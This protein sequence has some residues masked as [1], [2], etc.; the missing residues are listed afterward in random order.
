MLEIEMKTEEVNKLLKYGKRVQ[1]E[2][3]KIG[4]I[5]FDLSNF[6]EKC[7]IKEGYFTRLNLLTFHFT[8]SEKMSFEIKTDIEIKITKLA[9][10]RNGY[11][12]NVLRPF[13]K[14][15]KVKSGNRGR[16]RGI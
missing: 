7:E 13:G 1:C 9:D 15:R 11:S 10:F 5:Y 4:Y 8:H 16:Y 14:M 2:N 3:G 6:L 12:D